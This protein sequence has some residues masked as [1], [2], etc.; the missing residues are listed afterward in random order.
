MEQNIETTMTPERTEK[1]QRFLLALFLALAAT[2]NC[3][4]LQPHRSVH[5]Q[6]RR[7]LV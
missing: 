3:F 1:K 2:Y 6:C 5:Y 4:Y 7:L